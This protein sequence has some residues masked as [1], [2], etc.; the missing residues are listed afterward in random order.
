MTNITPDNL[1]LEKKAQ[2]KASASAQKK[3]DGIQKKGQKDNANEN[4]KFQSQ[5][6]KLQQ[7]LSK[8]QGNFDKQKG[9]KGE[10]KAAQNLAKAKATVANLPAE[11][12]ARI[13]K[14]YKQAMGS[15]AKNR[16][17]LDKGL[18]KAHTDQF[19]AS[20]KAKAHQS[21][22]YRIL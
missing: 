14:L 18:T 10:Q 17:S 5:E 4:K 7:N 9:K 3:L 12:K 15:M 21:S 22:K 6:K 16:A 1:A 11:H 20:G 19:D 8:V 2:N 13:N